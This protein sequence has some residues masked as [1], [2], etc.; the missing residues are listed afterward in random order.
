MP[1]KRE[2]SYL[3]EITYFNGP[4]VCSSLVYGGG[5]RKVSTPGIHDLALFLFGHL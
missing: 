2:D 1:G 3:V 4:W 5:I